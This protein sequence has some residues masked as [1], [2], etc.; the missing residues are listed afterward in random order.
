MDISR[1]EIVVDGR[2]FEVLD[3]PG[4]KGDLEFVQLSTGVI[5]DASY[6]DPCDGA[7]YIDPCDGP[8][9]DSIQITLP[10]GSSDELWVNS[11]PHYGIIPL[12]EICEEPIEFTGVITQSWRRSDDVCITLSVPLDQ[13]DEASFPLGNRKLTC[14]G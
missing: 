2:T 10:D 7:S 1:K 11:L 9:F 4:D 5:A 8:E 12:C 6:I 3:L 14:R 13:I